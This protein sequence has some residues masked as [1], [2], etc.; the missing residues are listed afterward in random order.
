MQPGIRAIWHWYRFS[1]VLH[2]RPILFRLTLSGLLAALLASN[3]LAQ[4]NNANFTPADIPG[5][6]CCNMRSDGKWISDIN[7]TDGTSVIPVGTPLKAT[8]FG[9]YRVHVEIYG[10]SQAI[11]N[12][13]S[14]QVNMDAFARRYIVP[15]DPKLKLAAFTP[16]VREAIT[17]SKL[18]PGMTREQVFMAVGYPVA[19]ENLL[20][21]AKLLRYWVASDAEFQ[22]AFDDNDLVKDINANP[23]VRSQ[24]V[25][26]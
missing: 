20:P 24:V 17:K 18:L 3:A 7:Y 22:V 11:G 8:G 25:L 23:L 2:R 1:T 10:M 9:R 14:R 21:T 26:E 19:S 13:Y 4:T 5:Y 6:L 15:E 16:K 12:D